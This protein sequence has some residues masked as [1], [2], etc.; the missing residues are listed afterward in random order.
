MA[1]HVY[2]KQ[3]RCLFTQSAMVPVYNVLHSV[4]QRCTMLHRT[5]CTHGSE[6]YI[7]HGLLVINVYSKEGKLLQEKII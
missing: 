7:I 4:L 3:C 5:V 2:F 1:Q 6:R